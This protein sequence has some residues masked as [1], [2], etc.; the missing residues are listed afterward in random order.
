MA[1]STFWQVHPEVIADLA[2]Y[3]KPGM[4]CLSSIMNKGSQASP[5]PRCGECP[6]PGKASFPER[7]W[8]RACSCCRML[9]G[10]AISGRPPTALR[11]EGH[12]FWEVTHP[13]ARSVGQA[14]A[15]P[16]HEKG[17]WEGVGEAQRL[18]ERRRGEKGGSAAGRA[19]SWGHAAGQVSR[20]HL[21]RGREG[22]MGEWQV[23]R[24]DNKGSDCRPG[25]RNPVCSSDPEADFRAPRAFS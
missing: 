17:K 20:S 5:N 22:A 10:K 2:A 21:S 12:L 25:E 14:L 13:S 9:Q 7:L 18:A 6:S 11:R 3:L 15:S 23:Y 16:W 24:T 19:F 8:L 4:S 1:S